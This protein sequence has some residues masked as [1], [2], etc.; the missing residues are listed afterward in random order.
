MCMHGGGDFA[1]LLFS[2]S[3]DADK[4]HEEDHDLAVLE[5]WRG[6]QVLTL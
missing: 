6:L 2:C 4:N 3:S 5:P 1:G